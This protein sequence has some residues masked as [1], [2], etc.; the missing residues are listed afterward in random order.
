LASCLQIADFSGLA[1]SLSSPHEALVISNPSSA[2]VGA[3]PRR[4]RRSRRAAPCCPVGGGSLPSVGGRRRR[5]RGFDLRCGQVVSGECGHARHPRPAGLAARLRAL[6]IAAER[7]PHCLDL[8]LL[9]HGPNDTAGP[10]CRLR[11]ERFVKAGRGTG[12]ARPR[13][14][15]HAKHRGRRC[16][17]AR[18]RRCPRLAEVVRTTPQWQCF[19]CRGACSVASSGSADSGWPR[20]VGPEV[21]IQESSARSS[22]DR[23]LGVRLGLGYADLREQRNPRH[24][25]EP[26]PVGRSVSP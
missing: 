2:F 6:P 23:L 9:P 5:C 1:S 3:P 8:T 20:S 12:Q 10:G 13:G 4:S 24:R 17:S 7:L 18:F 25:T 16:A 19:A 15:G 11:G 26:S 14:R 21:L 22:A